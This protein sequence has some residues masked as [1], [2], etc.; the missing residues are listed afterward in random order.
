M[1]NS[2]QK[3]KKTIESI[4]T[5]YATLHSLTNDKLRIRLRHIEQ[6]INKQDKTANIT[7]ASDTKNRSLEINKK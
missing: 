2:L 5:E 3:Y 1:S 4:N 6:F 7:P